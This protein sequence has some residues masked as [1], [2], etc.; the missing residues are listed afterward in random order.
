[1]MNFFTCAGHH[2]RS[3][4]AVLHSIH[5]CRVIMLLFVLL[6]TN[7][8][9]K[10]YVVGEYF[11]KD[12]ITYRVIDASTSSPKLA[13]YNVKGV[14]GTVTIPATVFDGIDT[15]FKVTQ[16]GGGHDSDNYEW[17]ST[18]TGVTL[19][20]TIT[21]IDSRAFAGSGITSLTLPASVTAVKGTKSMFW[22]T[23]ISQLKEIRVAAGN[24]SFISDNGV[25]Y[26]TGHKALIA[27]PNKYDLSSTTYIY[28]INPNCVKVYP[29]AIPSYLNIKKLNKKRETQKLNLE[30]RK[31]ILL[32]IV[33]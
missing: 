21:T 5:P 24:T 26:T 22:N 31:K 16:I 9:A 30:L 23:L 13:V 1:M 7:I 8:G 25:L 14:S 28:S 12:H 6:L 20:N 17:S 2:A 4:N 11:V 10:A 15:H 32:L 27:I 29:D 3:E 18:V 19:P 33:Y